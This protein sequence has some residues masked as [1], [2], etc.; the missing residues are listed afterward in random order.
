MRPRVNSRRISLVRQVRSVRHPNHPR[1][2]LLLDGRGFFL[3]Y[4]VSAG[5]TESR[6]DFAQLG[7]VGVELLRGN[8]GGFR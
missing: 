1:C 4:G 2:R 6:E 7:G 3:S 8:E 5:G